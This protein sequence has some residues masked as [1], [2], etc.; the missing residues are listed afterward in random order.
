MFF[1]PRN[2]ADFLFHGFLFIT[3]DSSYAIKKIDMSFNKGINIDWVNDVRIIQEFDKVH[4]KGWVLTKDEVS[5]D[6]GLSHNIMGMRGQK[7]AN[8]NNYSINEPIADS[9]FKGIG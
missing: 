7:V 8:Y 9:V 5:V 1:E 4:E 3:C 6:F 2:P